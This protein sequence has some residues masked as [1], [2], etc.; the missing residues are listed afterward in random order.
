LI[1]RGSRPRK[2][3]SCREAKTLPPIEGGRLGMGGLSGNVTRQMGP[4]LGRKVIEAHH[5]DGRARNGVGGVRR[6]ESSWNLE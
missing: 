3:L 4:P 6:E 5:K 2:Y 1:V